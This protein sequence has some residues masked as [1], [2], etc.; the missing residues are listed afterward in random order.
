MLVSSIGTKY[1]LSV[2]LSLLIICE[3][4]KTPNTYYYIFISYNQT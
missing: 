1:F 4:A 3:M 2:L